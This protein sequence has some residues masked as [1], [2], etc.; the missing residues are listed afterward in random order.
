MK[1]LLTPALVWLSLAAVQATPLLQPRDFSNAV[2][3][4]SAQDT[5]SMRQQNAQNTE[6]IELC[7]YYEDH[8]WKGRDST[9]KCT[10]WCK[11]TGQFKEDDGTSAILG[12]AQCK[13][14]GDPVSLVLK[15]SRCKTE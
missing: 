6:D 4:R 14:A 1:T 11:S 12:A 3:Q 13:F 9:N 7:N 2:E 15:P 10:E 8:Y 5:S